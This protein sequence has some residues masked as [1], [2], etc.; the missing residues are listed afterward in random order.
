MNIDNEN[1]E[2]SSRPSNPHGLE[3]SGSSLASLQLLQVPVTDLHVAVVVVQA[4]GEVSGVHLTGISS[5]LLLNALSLDWLLHL[6]G[7]GASEHGGDSSTQSVTNG[8]TNSHTSGGQSHVGKETWL[9][10]LSL[11]GSS[12]RS[13][14]S[15]GVSVWISSSQGASAVRWSTSS[16]SRT[17]SVRSWHFQKFWWQKITWV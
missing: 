2:C 4:L 6:I 9:L 15:L 10:W 17:S 8:Q 12:W 7:A 14:R 13:W 5:W 16:D 11:G 1:E 3:A